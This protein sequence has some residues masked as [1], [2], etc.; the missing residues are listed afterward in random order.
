MA[1]IGASVGAVAV[2]ALALVASLNS[3]QVS[4][5][6][7]ARFSDAYGVSAAEHRMEGALPLLPATGVI[8]YVSDLP[9]D[10]AAG[11]AGFLAGNTPSHRAR[12]CLQKNRGRT[13]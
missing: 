2:A 13:G 1:A 6:V 3:Y 4:Q 12:W 5:Q 8:G 10:Q 11:T 7:A 9:M